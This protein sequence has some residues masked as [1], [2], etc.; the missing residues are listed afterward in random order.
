[1]DR[2]EKQKK[3]KPERILKILLYSILVTVFLVLISFVGCLVYI[4]IKE[5]ISLSEYVFVKIPEAQEE[6]WVILK[7]LLEIVT[8]IVGIVTFVICLSVRSN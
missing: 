6:L 3:G 4:F 1:M 7:C 8:R 2:A 5:E